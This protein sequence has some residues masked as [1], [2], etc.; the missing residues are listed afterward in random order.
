MLG[1][2]RLLRWGTHANTGATD[3]YVPSLLEVYRGGCGL[4]RVQ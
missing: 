1:D 3:L 2:G 4:K